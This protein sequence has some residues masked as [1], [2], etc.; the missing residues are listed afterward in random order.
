M[1]D[2]V[3][4]F[5]AFRLPVYSLAL[6]LAAFAAVMSS[7][8]RSPYRLAQVIDVVL[9]A[10][11]LGLIGA[12]LE[13][14]ALTWEYFAAH[15][16]EILR[17]E[18]GGLGWHGAVLGA[19][20]GI[21]L[22]ARWRELDQRALLSRWAW[23]LPLIALA[24]WIGCAAAGCGYGREVDTLANYPDWLVWETRDVY[25]ILAP[26]YATAR[27]GMVLAVISTLVGIRTRGERRFWIM[28]ALLSAGMFGIGFLRADASPLVIGLRADQVLD[29]GFLVVAVQRLFTTEKRLNAKT[30]R[31]EG[32]KSEID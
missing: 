19:Y 30:R 14:V 16:D 9:A 27:F 1:L 26:R 32:A 4:Y 17:L 11:V 3:L 29:A 7:L 28:L 5:G 12:R 8:Y 13:Y 18:L 15:T 31:R 25:G 20:A 24:G 6:I 10:V 21:A 23:A 22:M 2:P